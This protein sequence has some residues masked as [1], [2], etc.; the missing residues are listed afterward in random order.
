MDIVY[1][2]WVNIYYPQCMN[3]LHVSCA[4]CVIS[5]M[6]QSDWFSLISSSSW[7]SRCLFQLNCCHSTAASSSLCC[8]SSVSQSVISHLQ[9][10]HQQAEATRL[11]VGGWANPA[12][13]WVGSQ[14]WGVSLHKDYRV[15][16][17]CRKYLWLLGRSTRGQETHH[18]SYWLLILKW[19]LTPYSWLQSSS[20]RDPSPFC[21]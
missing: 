6:M 17:Q 18:R 16:W 7:K 1:P 13:V 10:P 11:S 5:D 4:S 21:V 12:I 15:C 9:L 2:G 20:H 19:R 14:A 3:T 8:L